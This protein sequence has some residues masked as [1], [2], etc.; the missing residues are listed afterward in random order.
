MMMMGHGGGMPFG[1]LV[2]ILLLVATAWVGFRLYR[3]IGAG[4]AAPDGSGKSV[5]APTQGATSPGASGASGAAQPDAATLYRLA[6]DHSG[7]LSV[8]TVVVELGVSPKT[9]E[10][11][12]QA[13]S[14]EVHVRM[15]VQDDGRILYRFLELGTE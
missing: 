11:A 10:A 7:T 13:I 8:S 3:R 15:D 12:L 1:P 9:A 14:D 6:R 5:D 4:N 2:G